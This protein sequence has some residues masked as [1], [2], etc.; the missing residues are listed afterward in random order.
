MLGAGC[1]NLTQLHAEF[2]LRGLPDP[3]PVLPVQ[4][5][6]QFALSGLEP[7]LSSTLQQQLALQDHSQAQQ[8]QQQQCDSSSGW[9]PLTHLS[10]THGC[11]VSNVAKLLHNCPALRQLELEGLGPNGDEV[12][13]VLAR[14]ARQLTALQLSGCSSMSMVGCGILAAG[15][16]QLRELSLVDVGLP[17]SHLLVLLQG[18]GSGSSSKQAASPACPCDSNRDVGDGGNGSSKCSSGGRLTHLHIERCRGMTSEVLSNGV[19]G[20]HNLLQLELVGCDNMYG[21][22]ALLD[23]VWQLSRLQVIRVWGCKYVGAGFARSWEAA[24]AARLLAV[25]GSRSA[26]ASVTWQATG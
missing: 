22:G 2:A 11:S 23:L 3:G 17:A 10:V 1:R 8:Q 6:R 12:A 24:A 21:E 16:R 4:P 14:R 25:P 15:L 19:A 20:L 9:P 18:L 7:V 5:G 13:V 26:V